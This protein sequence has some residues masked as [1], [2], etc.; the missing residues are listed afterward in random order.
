MNIP[1]QLEHKGTRILPPLTGEQV[2][3][4]NAETR[5]E[6]PRKEFSFLFLKSGGTEMGFNVRLSA[7]RFFFDGS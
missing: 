4:L 3:Q 1:A 2:L 6:E 5:V 7:V